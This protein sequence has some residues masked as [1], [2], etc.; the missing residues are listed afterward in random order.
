[1]RPEERIER[2]LNFAVSQSVG[3]GSA[4]AG[5]ITVMKSL[6]NQ[7]THGERWCHPGI[8]VWNSLRKVGAQLSVL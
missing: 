1:M 2:E 7:F 8:G 5:A 4:L 6:D 3:T